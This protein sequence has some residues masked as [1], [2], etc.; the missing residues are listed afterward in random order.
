[1]IT[2]KGLKTLTNITKLHLNEN[3]NISDVGINY[4]K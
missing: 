4:L 1:M 2:D 3:T